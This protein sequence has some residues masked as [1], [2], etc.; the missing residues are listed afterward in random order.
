M[1]WLSCFSLIGD[2]VFGGVCR[3]Q[4][5]RCAEVGHFLR[6]W[7]NEPCVQVELCRP[8]KTSQSMEETV[9]SMNV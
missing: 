7:I 2:V 5:L 6:S 9:L 1:G 3:C 4:T 8:D